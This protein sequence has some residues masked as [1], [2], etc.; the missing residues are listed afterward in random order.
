MAGYTEAEKCAHFATAEHLLQ[1]GEMRGQTTEVY[2]A[3]YR[4]VQFIRSRT[5]WHD[6][7]LYKRGEFWMSWCDSTNPYYNPNS[8]KPFSDISRANAIEQ[9]N[10]I[11]FIRQN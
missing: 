9:V 4:G 11:R 6:N 10:W 1:N 8:P 7:I 2:T 3:V 5:I